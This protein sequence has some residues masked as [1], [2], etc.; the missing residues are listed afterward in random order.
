MNDDIGKVVGT[1]TGYGDYTTVIPCKVCGGSSLLL[2][3]HSVECASCFRE[4]EAVEVAT[5]T[6]DIA[7]NQLGEVVRDVKDDEARRR[8]HDSLVL[9]SLTLALWAERTA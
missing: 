3:E 4:K 8:L 1:P 2:F 7:L 9:W 5:V 6:F